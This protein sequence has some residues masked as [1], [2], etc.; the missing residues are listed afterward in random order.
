MLSGVKPGQISTPGNKQTIVIAAPKTGTSMAGGV[1]PTKILTTM[2]RLAT[3]TSQS[4]QTQF[5]V[6]TTR[7][8]GTGTV[9]QISGQ[10]K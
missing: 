9:Q 6:V 10:S 5:I 7:P 1:T 8:G 4:G 3:P 2:P